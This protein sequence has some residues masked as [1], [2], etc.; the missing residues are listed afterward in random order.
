MY[1][2]WLGHGQSHS[3]RGGL[4]GHNV[5]RTDVI[6]A[7]THFTGGLLTQVFEQIWLLAF[8]EIK[9]VIVSS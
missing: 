2:S 8:P 6:S 5:L 9:N 3:I 7:D 1:P 4:I